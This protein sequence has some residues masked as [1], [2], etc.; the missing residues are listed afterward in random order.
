L[1]K[2][3][4]SLEHPVFQSGHPSKYQVRR[5]LTK[6][7]KTV[8]KI[9]VDEDGWRKSICKCFFS[10]K[11][12]ICTHVVGLAIRLGLVDAV[13]VDSGEKKKKR[14][15]QKKTNSGL[16]IQLNYKF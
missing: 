11:E 4:G 6:I 14:G 8:C 10:Q 13:D 2:K 7:I 3:E 12:Y 1:T 16:K 9:V 15:P 5:C